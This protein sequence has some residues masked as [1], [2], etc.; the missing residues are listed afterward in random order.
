VVD[1]AGQKTRSELAMIAQHFT[2]RGHE[3][4]VCD[5]RA[6]TLRGRRLELDGRPIDIVY[7]RVLVKELLERQGEVTALLDAYRHGRICM[8]NSLRSYVA[9]NKGILPLLFEGRGRASIDCSASVARSVLLPPGRGWNLDAVAPWVLKKCQGSGGRDVILPERWA[10]GST[11]AVTQDL[12]AR[13]ECWIAQEFMP[14]PL[15]TIPVLQGNRLQRTSCYY[16]WNPFIFNGSYAGG[17]V[18]VS[19]SMLISLSMGGGVL[20]TFVAEGP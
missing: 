5:P 9:S 17:I 8:V 19:K 7:R 10:A 6:L 14:P 15:L 11:G 13:G 12:R 20:P 18:R 2:T 16:N 1:W 3:S 4:F